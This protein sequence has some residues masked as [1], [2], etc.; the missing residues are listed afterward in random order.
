MPKLN[1]AKIFKLEFEPPERRSV[2]N[3]VS[4]MIRL[5]PDSVIT[6]R[7]FTLPFRNHRQTSTCILKNNKS[8]PLGHQDHV[9]LSGVAFH[10]LPCRVP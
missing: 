3:S 1:F 9:P 2:S 5:F 6:I 8:Q 4:V 10:L 7:N